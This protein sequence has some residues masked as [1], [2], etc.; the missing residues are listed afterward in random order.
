MV[1]HNPE[2]AERYATRIVTLKDGVIRSD[3]MPYEPDTQ[4]L[5]APCTR[6]WAARPCRCSP[7]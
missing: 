6:T 3:T 1:T 4:T 2:L 7:R 5:A